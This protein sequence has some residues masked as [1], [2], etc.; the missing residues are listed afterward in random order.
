MS[1]CEH[2]GAPLQEV[3]LQRRKWGSVEGWVCVERGGRGVLKLHLCSAW[4]LTKTRRDFK[5]KGKKEGKGKDEKKKKKKPAKTSA[6][7][8]LDAPR[9]LIRVRIP[10]R[11]HFLFIYFFLHS[12]S[13]AALCC[14][15]ASAG[16]A[17]VADRSWRRD[18]GRKWPAVSS[19]ASGHNFLIDRDRVGT[20]TSPLKQGC[21]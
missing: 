12:L 7:P 2:V 13:R 14:S 9:G 18:E 17:V 15:S 1:A 6:F 19:E 8:L 3:Q 20:L 16:P 10:P 5:R 21:N 11:A 4:A